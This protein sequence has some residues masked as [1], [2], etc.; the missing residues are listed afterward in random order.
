METSLVLKR[1][2]YTDTST[3]GQLYFDG[4]K[5]CLTLEDTVRKGEK[6]YG[7]TAIPAGT[8][9]IA[10]NYSPHLKM[11]IPLL[12]DVPNFT[13]IRIHSG[14]T[15]ADTEGCILVGKSKSDDDKSI[16]ESRLALS[17]LMQKLELRMHIGPIF[18]SVG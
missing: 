9:E 17:A 12:L 16:F 13:K 11:F 10:F 14:N 2:F 1:Q 5:E 8:Y 7:K 3:I 15:P 6:I 4:E 18:I